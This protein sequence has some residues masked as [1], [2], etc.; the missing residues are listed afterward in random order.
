MQERTSRSIDGSYYLVVQLHDPLTITGWVLG[1]EQQRARPAPSEAKDAPAMVDCPVNYL[2]DARIEAG[3]ITATGQN[4]QGF[5]PSH[6][7][8][9][10]KTIR[11]WDTGFAFL[12]AN[13][14][15]ST[16]L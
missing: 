8:T 14:S 6:G 7:E 10:T 3:D 2:F 4:C 1:I 15:Y 16:R 12:K 11:D 9:S 5:L 13:R